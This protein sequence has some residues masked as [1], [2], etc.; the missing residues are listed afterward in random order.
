ML[1]T[2]VVTH[3]LPPGQGNI[4]L[5]VMLNSHFSTKLTLILYIHVSIM[6][7]KQ[8][9]MANKLHIS[10]VII[11]FKVTNEPLEPK[12]EMDPVYNLICIKSVL[13]ISF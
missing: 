4:G 10:K 13:L 9:T 1:N 12:R 2:H 8:S 5:S 6:K 11:L 3:S 7:L